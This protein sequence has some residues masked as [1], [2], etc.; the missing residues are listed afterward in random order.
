LRKSG[1]IEVVG[2]LP[3]IAELSNAVSSSANISAHA[4][5]VIEMSVKRELIQIASRIH[6]TAYEDTTDAFDLLEKTASEFEF[7]VQHSRPE[8]ST[9][10]IKAQWQETLITE[11]PE[12]FPPLITINN[13]PVCTINNHSLLVGK[14][15]SRKTLFIV[16]LI[17]QYLQENP[18]NANKVLL[19][20][21]EQGK[22]HV[23]EIRSKIYE[24]TKLW[25]P[26]FYLRGLSP[27]ERKNFIQQT[28]T[29]WASKPSIVVIDGI[30]D[31]MSNI[32]DPDESTDLI[33]W[34][35]KITLHY[36]IHVINILHLNKT[37]SNPRGHIGTE[38]MNKAEVTIEME[39]DEKNGCTIVKCESSRDRPFETFA[40]THDKDGLPEIIGSPLGGN[41]LAVQDKR[42]RLLEIFSDGEPLRYQEVV[43][44]IKI[45]FALGTTRAIQMLATFIREGWVVRNGKKRS[46]DAVYKCMISANGQYTAPKKKEED[47]NQLS[48]EPVSTSEI[49]TDDLP[50]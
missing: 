46:P 1:K 6:Q 38:L 12:E 18:D 15:K 24:M 10:K 36:N 13:V 5:V 25:V 28:V 14:K 21:T 47:K 48:L 29:A 42:Q 19:F 9:E 44:E 31:L 34:L 43:D 39:L 22:R 16:L 49:N 50:F 40:F 35:E 32:N 8:N 2:G 7:F 4:R 27:E 45:Q 3:F 30:R 33:V 26:V 17:S 41:I 11:R 37:D 23:F 20:D